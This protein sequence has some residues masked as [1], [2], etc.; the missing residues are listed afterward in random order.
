MPPGQLNRYL[1]SFMSKDGTNSTAWSRS[2]WVVF[3]VIFA[4]ILLI[5]IL[6]LYQDGGHWE[7]LLPSVALLIMAVAHVAQLKGWAQRLSQVICW[8]I[9]IVTVV[10]FIIR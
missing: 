5:Q 3:A 2:A 7:S 4:V 1:L 9:L 8:G 10:M 6:R